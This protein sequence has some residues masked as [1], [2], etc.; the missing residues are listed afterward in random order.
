MENIH[1]QMQEGGILKATMNSPLELL[2]LL[3]LLFYKKTLTLHLSTK[4][5]VKMK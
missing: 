2:T 3:I 5:L 1:L 4:S